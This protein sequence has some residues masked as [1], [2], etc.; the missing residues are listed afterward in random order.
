MFTFTLTKQIEH[1]HHHVVVVTIMKLNEYE[2]SSVLN[3]AFI[4]VQQI[5]KITNKSLMKVILNS[6]KSLFLIYSFICYAERSSLINIF[7][8]ITTSYDF[9][10]LFI[11]SNMLIIIS[12][13][14][15]MKAKNISEIFSTDMRDTKNHT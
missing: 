7:L 4:V 11:N 3:T 2:I 8:I 9:F 6:I 14:T 5:K 13:H 10:T 12:E 1:L 15:N